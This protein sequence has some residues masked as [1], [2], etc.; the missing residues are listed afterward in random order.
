MIQIKYDEEE[1]LTNDKHK[2]VQRSIR[3]KEVIRKI[4]QRKKTRKENL[5]FLHSFLSFQ[6]RPFSVEWEKNLTLFNDLW[7]LFID[8]D[9]YGFLKSGSGG[10]YYMVHD[11]HSLTVLSLR[12][13]GQVHMSFLLRA[14][15]LFGPLFFHSKSQTKDSWL[16]LSILFTFKVL[17][18]SFINRL[19]R[20]L[21]SQWQST[22]R[23]LSLGS[24]R[25]PPARTFFS[26]PTKT[27][28]SPC[29]YHS[30]QTHVETHDGTPCIR[31]GW[32]L[33]GCIIASPR[34]SIPCT[35]YGPCTGCLRHWDLR[36]RPRDW[37]HHGEDETLILS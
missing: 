24:L 2:S 13:G 20:T 11:L 31:A 18:Q 5:S 35:H 4:S 9:E 21:V 1:L 34:L 30:H 27:E 17:I 36:V 29:P 19:A 16:N 7:A 8:E 32:F 25:Q 14:L 23:T 15:T 6:S 28:S 37:S 10:S 22:R 12:A 26:S 33:K 3:G